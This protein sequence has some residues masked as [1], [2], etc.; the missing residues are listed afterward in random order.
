M[1]RESAR[2]KYEKETESARYTSVSCRHPCPIQATRSPPVPC[3]FD[4]W[5]KDRADVCIM[6]I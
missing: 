4:L 3:A 5:V 6:I 2:F 1:K